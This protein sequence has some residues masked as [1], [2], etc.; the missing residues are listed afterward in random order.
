MVTAAKT[1]FGIFC[2]DRD[3]TETLSR[4]T[5]ALKRM[6]LRK[7]AM[8][9]T[10]AQYRDGALRITAA[11]MPPVCIHRASTGEVEQIDLPGMPLGAVARFPYGS[12]VVQLQQGDAVL[13]MTDG[14]PERLGAEDE[15]LGYERAVEVFRAAASGGA[16]EIIESLH[17]AAEQW[18]EGRAA[19][20]DVTF[21]VL[22]MRTA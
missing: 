3:L 17:H 16:A 15:L 22:K 14:F 8:A 10:L 12:Q 4:S 2:R 6:N 5:L 11:G 9:L 18:A 20:D 13:F 7:L 19:D 21:V 1:L